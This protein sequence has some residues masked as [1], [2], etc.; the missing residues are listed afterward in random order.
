MSCVSRRTFRN[1]V[2]AKKCS[3]SR[4][5]V[6]LLLAVTICFTSLHVAT[7][8]GPAQSDTVSGDSIRKTSDS[9]HINHYIGMSDLRELLE[10]HRFFVIETRAGLG[11]RLRAL[12]TA[13]ALAKH[14]RR[15]LL[16]VWISDPHA[17]CRFDELFETVGMY[18]SS[19]DVR[20]LFSRADS[21]I[22]YDYDTKPGVM[23]NGAVDKHIYVRSG[24]VLNSTDFD[25][26]DVTHFLQHDLRL[27]NLP[28]ELAM[29]YSQMQTEIA[30][31]T[32][33]VGV[34]IRMKANLSQDIPNIET[35]PNTDT[36]AMYNM[37][38]SVEHRRGCH[39]NH[40]VTRMQA[41]LRENPK[42]VFFVSVDSSEARTVLKKAAFSN[43][44]R[45]V[46]DLDIELR[47]QNEHFRQL[48]CLQVAMVEFKLLAQT[49]KLLLSEWSS[50]S[51]LVRMLAG[52]GTETFC[53]CQQCT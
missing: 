9:L 2:T 27:K 51:E 26:E 40:F 20:P 52:S 42:Y 25:F 33:A 29:R 10:A 15:E 39:V 21:S 37:L 34:H 11:N 17:Q 30:D 23:I 41:M 14:T 38:S 12:S 46:M 49:S 28:L 22:F 35:L 6:N 50:A 48:F 43:R 5:V 18:V 24:R 16:L 8:N 13:A 45:F 44:V 7:R 4:R 36:S 19:T 1:K 47:C 3:F 32:Y 31:T 53:G